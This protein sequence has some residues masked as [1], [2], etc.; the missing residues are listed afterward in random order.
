M[1]VAEGVEGMVPIKGQVKDIITQAIG[2]IKSGMYYL[3]TKTIKDLHNKAKF[4]KISQS[5]LKESHPHDIFVTNPGENY[6]F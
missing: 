3:G 5:S 6:Q 1:L 4:L 2:G